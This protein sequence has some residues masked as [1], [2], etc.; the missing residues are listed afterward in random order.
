[1]RANPA[2]R[3]PYCFSN[4]VLAGLVSA[5][6]LAGAPRTAS[7]QAGGPLPYA[8]IANPLPDTM[9]QLYRDSLNLKFS[10][11]RVNQAGYSTADR[12]FFYT[13]GTTGTAFQVINEAK[14]Q[15]ATGTLTPTGHSTTGQ[16]SI[17][18]A[19]NAFKARN[20]RYGMLSQVSAGAVSEG[21]IPVGIQPG[22]YRIVVGADTS[23]P[24]VVDE[25]VYSWVKDALIKFF[26]VNR[27]GNAD[28]WFHPPAHLKDG[29]NGDGTLTGGWFDCGDHLK[30]SMSMSYAT[31]MLGLVAAA[32][33]DRDADHY[34]RNH[35]NT[36]LTDGVPDILYE[37]KVGTDFYLKSY[38]LAKGDPSKMI[39]SIGAF[40]GDHGWWGQPQFQDALPPDRGGPVRELRTE[41]GANIMGRLAA[42]FAFFSKQY[43]PFDKPYADRCLAAAKKFYDYGKANFKASGSSGAY[44]T[45]TS[46]NDD[47]ALAAVALLWATRDTTYKFDLIANPALGKFGNP[48][49][50]PGS[51]PGGWMVNTNTT[52]QKGGS[53]TSYA[54]VHTP[55]LWAFYRLILKDPATAA[56]C[57]IDAGQR[58]GIVENV[59]FNIIDNLGWLQGGSAS[60]DLPGANPQLPGGHALTYDPLWKLNTKADVIWVWN[61]YIAG[62][63]AEFFCYYDVAK[64]LQGIALPHTPAS[65]DWKADQV[66]QLIVRQMDY[67]LGVNPWDISMI[68]GVGAKNFNHPHH[69]GSNPEG[70]NVPGAFYKYRPPVGALQGGFP[71]GG[72]NGGA[73]GLY[74]EDWEDYT[75]SESCLDGTTTMLL[76]VIGLAKEDVVDSLGIQV[77]IEY[78]GTDH[79]IIVVRQSRYG[80][81]SIRYGTAATALNAVKAGDS[82]GIEHRIVLTGLTPATTYYFQ[83][84]AKDLKGRAGTND[85]GGNKFVFT[86][87]AK[88]PG[89]AQIGQVKVCNVTHNTAEI[90]WY[91]PNGAFD[92]KVVYGTGKPPTQVHDGD[93]TG[94]PVKFHY[95]ILD[96]LK[97]KTQYWF[98]VESNGVR[99]DN[100]GQFY[101]FTT[102]IEHVKFDVRALTYE[103]PSGASTKK[104]LG[105]NLVNQDIKSYDSLDVRLYVRATEAQMADFGVRADIGQAYL[106][107]GFLD[108]TNAF[109]TDLDMLIQKVKPVRMDE[110]FDAATNTYSW[111]V[112]LPMGN[113]KMASGA[114]FRVDVTFVKR[115]EHNDLLDEPATYVPGSKDWSWSPHSRAQGDPVDFGG[116]KPG[117]KEDV[118]DKYV[119]TEVNPYITVYR[120]G[121]FVWGYSPSSKEQATKITNYQMDVRITSPLNNPPEDYKKLDQASSTAIVKGKVTI[122]DA[123]KLTDVWVNGERVANLAQVATYDAAANAWNLNV[124][125]KLKAG[126]NEV[127]LTLFGGADPDCQGCVGCA[128]ANRHFYLEY[129]K[130]DA[131]PSTLTLLTP[132]GQPVP[133]LAVIG[134]TAFIVEVQDKNGDLTANADQL[135][136]TVANPNQGDNLQVTLAETGPRTGVFRSTVPVQV[137]DLPPA[138]TGAGQI[139]MSEGD[140]IWV[141][142]VDPTDADD[143]SQAFLYTPATFPQA[144]SGWF[145]DSDGDGAV[146]KAV[147]NYSMPLKALPDSL[148]LWFPQPAAQRTFAS[149]AGGLTMLGTRVEAILAPPFAAGVTAFAGDN[150]NSGRS[151]LTHDGKPRVSAFTLADSVGPV[152]TRAVLSPAAAA[153]APDTLT[154]TFSEPIGY[155]RTETRPFQGK[156]GG[157]ALPASSITVAGTV[158]VQAA[159]LV[160][161]LS[162]GADPLLAAGDSLRIA[163]GIADLMGNRPAANNRFVLVEGEK[164]LPPAVLEMEWSTRVYDSRRSGPEGKPF[165]ISAEDAAGNWV[166]VQGSVGSIARNC[167]GS[168]CGQPLPPAADGGVSVPSILI[169]SDRPFRYE[170][171]VFNNFGVFVAGI[172]G[173]VGAPLLDGTGGSSAPVHADPKTGHYRM[174][175]IW[176][177]KA[178]NGTR[179]GTGAYV[180]KATILSVGGSQPTVISSTKTVGL[181]RRD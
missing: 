7:A 164:R 46:I 1:M 30:E 73:A 100:Q 3:L 128:F 89:A 78:V 24:F 41:V 49:F 118:D 134:Q 59:I 138:S 13:V 124:P 162:P 86:T 26:G 12:K 47:M 87:L 137:L 176:N 165:V 76:P 43:A 68:Y 147:V 161:L 159:R 116:V 80:T 155:A 18:A 22:R 98:Y 10:R 37:T 175:L 122:T 135:Q 11:I 157:A 36:H 96:S 17:Y 84:E 140:S 63:S 71:P 72:G 62:N 125:I 25:K 115:N 70:T 5:A 85:N 174:R 90:L 21:E 150:R 57:G 19:F 160:L 126:P 69:R 54:N 52:L 42:G 149:A 131:F 111:Y 143:S 167:A 92:S 127:D 171:V 48:W 45:E 112:S 121:Q 14:A 53:N 64:D 97:E 109:K 117:T 104:Y 130:A 74:N 173:E 79:A 8:P 156:Q 113:A 20:K 107:T 153:G 152:L 81:A 58:L 103:I 180:W 15:V 93:I 6:C 91:T 179:A 95:V 75:H 141:T 28:S 4:Y 34:G 181:L 55:T 123:G 102:K 31:A 88:P 170:S 168:D 172:S 67:M 169:T 51:W 56:A 136:V 114:R 142:Y 163:A 151:F 16:L 29:P 9:D 27:D 65:V 99:D 60:I 119:T 132:G 44:P 110:T 178:V 32:L 139:A 166:P 120:K 108:P 158:D 35:N 129:N 106:S 133:P 146:D 2:R 105:F 61:R 145:L 39:T 83:A 50:T 66:R 77:R 144:I 23:S 82:A 33:P 38:D 101:T 154:V 40:G 148:Q 177:G 94:H